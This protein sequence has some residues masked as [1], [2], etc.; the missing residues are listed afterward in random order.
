MIVRSGSGGFHVYWCID[1]P[2]AHRDVEAARR[3][4]Q[5]SAQRSTVLSRHRRHR[6][7]RPHPARAD[8]VQLQARPATL[9]ELTTP[10]PS[11]STPWTA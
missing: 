10:A 2:H 1:K 6:R 9:G 5:G 4:A 11:A 8:Y 7:R 3:C